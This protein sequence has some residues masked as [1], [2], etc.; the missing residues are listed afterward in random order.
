MCHAMTRKCLLIYIDCD[1]PFLYFAFTKYPHFQKFARSGKIINTTVF[2]G[3][4][5]DRKE[6]NTL[7]DVTKKNILQR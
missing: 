2:I 3:T 7:V 4:K 5:R 1:L 6:A